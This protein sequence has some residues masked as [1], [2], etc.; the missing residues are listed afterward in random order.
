[1][2][3]KSFIVGLCVIL[4][5]ATVSTPVEAQHDGRQ[6]PRQK[7][8][9]TE[10]VEKGE[11]DRREKKV[12]MTKQELATLINAI[13]TAAEEDEMNGACPQQRDITITNNKDRD[14]LYLLLQYHN[15]NAMKAAPV[16]TQPGQPISVGG[17]LYYPAG[18]NLVVTQGAQGALPTNDAD[19]IK[20]LEEELAR[21]KAAQQNP[22]RDDDQIAQQLAALRSQL[23]ELEKAPEKAPVYNYDNRRV[24]HQDRSRNNVQLSRSVFFKVNSDVLNAEGRE[25]VRNVADFVIND[26]RALVL[27]YGYASIDG[28]VDF[29]NKLAAK[30]AASVIKALQE[31]GVPAAAIKRYDNG[32][33]TTPAKRTD[34]RRVD[35]DVIY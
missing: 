10:R 35:M 20:A 22:Q 30:R 32:V 31:A 25:A 27:V 6:A 34:A 2:T 29:N 13:V 12:V 21:L 15:L 11:R 8:D 3:K 1:M 28:P 19:R 14:L 26:P 7:R 5:S 18:S 9:R 16:Y 23:E 33:D 17:Q 4:L 24:I